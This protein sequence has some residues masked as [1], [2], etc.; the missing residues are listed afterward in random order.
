MRMTEISGHGRVINGAGL[1]QPYYM[2]ATWVI[3]S[4]DEESVIAPLLP[5]PGFHAWTDDFSNIITIIKQV[6]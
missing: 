4:P 3:L 6:P 5:K 1:D 2:G